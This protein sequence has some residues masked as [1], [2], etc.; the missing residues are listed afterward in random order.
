MSSWI[1]ITLLVLLLGIWIGI[2]RE[3]RNGLLAYL[4]QT[5]LIVVL[6][7]SDTVRAQ[8]L[9]MLMACIGLVG[10]RVI[11]IPLVL[12]NRLSDKYLRNR[13]NLFV[14]SPAYVVLVSLGLGVLAIAV[15][16]ALGWHQVLAL[17]FGLA[18]ATLLVGLAT[19]TFSEHAGRQV[20]GL[21][22]ADNG[23]DVAIA[24]VLSHVSMGSDYIIFVDITLAVI[25]FVILIL[26]MDH[27]G[28]LNLRDYHKLRG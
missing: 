6:Y 13:Y 23:V 18:L 7:L 28:S 17:S 3:L 11:I 22:S 12:R 2:V 4:V 14:V 1:W 5:L 20:L 10:A 15:A 16:A 24:A 21:L 19:V 26:R 25:L 8:S 27:T 9:D